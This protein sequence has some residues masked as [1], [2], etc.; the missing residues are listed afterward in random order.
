MEENI[1]DKTIDNGTIENIQIAPVGEFI[2]SATDGS[3]V[4]ENITVEKLESLA[5]KLN[6]S[7]EVLCD[8]D[9]QSCKVGVEKN[10]KAAGWFSKWIVDPIKGL[11]ATLSL[12]KYGRELLENREYR[13]TSPVFTLNEDGTVADLHSVALTNTPAFKGHITP[14]INSESTEILKDKECLNEETKEILTMDITKEEL[15]EMIYSIISDMRAAEKAADIRRE[16]VEEVIENECSTGT[17]KEEVVKNEVSEEETTTE[18]TT[19]VPEEKKVEEKEEVIKYETLN[20][21]PMIKD[22]E[23]IWKKLTGQEFLDW[24]AKN[25]H[26]QI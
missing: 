6:K 26:Y 13:Y 23:P 25:P 10:S 12:T 4:E 8:V 11:F 9:H 24:A 17:T 1:L 3:P 20:S 18:T 22:V 14:I 5:D 7:D 2:G 19:E 21:A 16:V 15:K